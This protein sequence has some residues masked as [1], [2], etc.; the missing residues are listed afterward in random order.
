VQTPQKI[1][2]NKIDR[3]LIEKINKNVLTIKRFGPSL[4]QDLRK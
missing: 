4:A 2:S 3:F 1:E